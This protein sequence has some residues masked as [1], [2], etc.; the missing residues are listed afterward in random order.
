VIMGAG[1]RGIGSDVVG[2]DII[3]PTVADV[4]MWVNGAS[5]CVCDCSCGFGF[6]GSGT[7]ISKSFFVD[8]DG[9]IDE[10]E[11]TRPEKKF[12]E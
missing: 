6:N 3:E 8:C 5:D 1:T 2:D 9:I 10:Y 7:L 11:P 4:E 12:Y